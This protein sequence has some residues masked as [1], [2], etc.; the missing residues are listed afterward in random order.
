MR[1]R[2]I[3]IH[4]HFYQPPRE[5]PWLE[6]VETQDTAAPY[7]DWNERITAECY[8]PNASSR[9]LDARERIVKIV[10]NYSAISFNFGPTLLSWMEQQQ[11]ETYAAILDA[12]RASRE[13]FGGHGSAI[14]QAYNHMILP[15]ANARDQR[16]QVRWGIRDF[17]HRFGR[18]PEAM[19]LPETAVD[20]ASLEALAAEGMAYTILAP[21]QALR[22]RKIGDDDWTEQAGAIDPTMPYRCKL[23]S[24]RSIDL[25]FYDGPISQAVAF[26]RLLARGE[27]LA[28]RLLGA[29]SEGRTHPQLVNIATDG[30]TYGHHHPK[31]DMALAYA[32]DYIDE[33]KLSRIMN[34]GQFLAEVPPTHEVEIVERTAWSCDHSLGRWERDCGCSTGGEAGWNQ[35]W[36][37]P[38]RAAL[39][40]LRDECIAIFERLGAGLL[41][42]PWEARDEY[43]SV[44]LDRSEDNVDR[45]LAGHVIAEGGSVTALELLE[46]QRNAMLMYTSCGWFFND[47]SGIETVQV[48]HY[49]GRVIQ[50]AENV[51]GRSLELEFLVRVASARSNLP[52]HGDARLIYEREVKPMRIDLRRVSAHYAVAS[53]FDNFAHDDRVYCYRVRQND[54]ESFRAGRA[55]MAVGSIT[56]TSLITREEVSLEFAV[57]HLGETELTGGVRPV[58]TPEHYEAM[59]RDLSEDM[60][61]NGVSSVIRVLDEYFDESSL[62]I[63]ALFRDEQRRILNL[64]CDATLN[65]AESAFRQLHERYDPLMRFH[66]ALGVPLPNV[67]RTAAEFDINMQLRRMAAA[68]ELPLDDLESRLRESRDEGVVLDEATLMSLTRAVERAAADFARKPEDLELL[69]RWE[70]LVAIVRE[71]E[72]KVDLRRPQNDYYR[73]KKSVRPTTAAN[74]GNGSSS[75]NRWLQ[76]F[77]ALGEKLSI[78]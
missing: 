48:L 49:A 77:D 69:E 70:T 74:A 50:I 47:I 25:F 57:I 19:W 61:V 53:L 9:I 35:Q 6:A 68:D 42:D 31:G 37:T 41:R 2:Y 38:L 5:N 4:G 26:E 10:N 62:S 40:W 34:Y 71:A 60:R 33:Q 67:L 11:P 8:G 12:D 43:V 76:H 65:E 24:S 44:I 73:L 13:R 64:L 23:P 39:D 51:S 1:I 7:H 66:A 3:C 52:Q 58:S 15:L 27:N 22:W 78:G 20:I 46:M 17:E 55:R 54:F 59:K 28:H 75:A 29:F 72:V 16:T 32:L 21:H 18:K 45:F 36:R 14:A 56:V 30:E 63:R